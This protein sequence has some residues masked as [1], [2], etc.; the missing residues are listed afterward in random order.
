MTTKLLAA[1]LAAAALGTTAAALPASAQDGV[2]PVSVVG[3]SVNVE[4]SGGNAEGLAPSFTLGN[5]A[6][7]FVNRSA[8][9]A[10]SVEFTVRSG[11]QEQ[12]IVD[13][14]TFAPGTQV[15]SEF[16]P[17]IATPTSCDVDA[18]TFADGSTWHA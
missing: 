5:L 14:G 12:T 7:S 11:N 9:A 16:L 2:S 15:T 13:Q 17:T 18:V 8:Q 3:C 6:I 4:Q 1:S 10:T